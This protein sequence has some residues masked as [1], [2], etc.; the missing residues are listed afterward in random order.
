MNRRVPGALA[1][2]IATASGRSLTLVCHAAMT[3]NVIRVTDSAATLHA[4]AARPVVAG[5]LGYEH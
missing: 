4:V 2:T 5:R 1:D 3:A